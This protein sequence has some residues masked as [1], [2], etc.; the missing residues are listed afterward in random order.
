MT[1]RRWFSA[2]A[3]I[4]V[5][6]VLA[7][8]ANAGVLS[9]LP[10]AAS[11]PSAHAGVPKISVTVTSPVP[12]LPKPPPIV[13]H[14]LKVVSSVTSSLHV[15][16]PIS[17]TTT[18]TSTASSTATASKPPTTTTSPA[19]APAGHHSAG[20]S[21]GSPV[22]VRRHSATH[23][24]PTR[25]RVRS[26]AHGSV[27]GRVAARRAAGSSRAGSGGG[28]RRHR[29]SPQRAAVSSPAGLLS[30]LGGH[31]PLPLPVPNW[32]KPIILALLLIAIGFGI[33]AGVA[34]RRVRRLER[35]GRIL[36]ADFETMQAALVPPVPARV[37]GLDVSVGYQ[38][39][40]GP[41]AGG[42]FYEIFPL[43]GDRVAIILGDVSGH[44]PDALAHA[45]RM[46]FALRAYVE[47]GLSPR[48][49]LKLAGR[50][51][52]RGDGG[53]FTTV[54][55]AVY[56]PAAASLSYATAGHPPP[57]VVNP[58]LYEPVMCCASP[59]LG[60][61]F[62]TGARQTIV[63]FASG[64]RACFFTDGLAEAPTGDGL[65]G[66]EGIVELLAPDGFRAT[67]TEL[68]ERVRAVADRTRDDMATCLVEAGAGLPAGSPAV[69]GAG[70]GSPTGSSA[71]VEEFEVA[72]G[73]LSRA[74]LERFLQA[75]G[76]PP[77]EIARAIRKAEAICAEEQDALVTVERGTSSA[78][79]AVTAS[80]AMSGPG[81]EP[82]IA[83]VAA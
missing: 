22:T 47:T 31:I 65:L 51:A 35:Q 33:R 4:G 68:L 28:S 8:A 72:H 57:I 66:R 69:V 74:S 67:A 40:G 39:A 43:S 54:V 16:V 42:D 21:G 25:R 82:T 3:A 70:T 26:A 37:G 63:P 53:L 10:R 36:S 20:G 32:S 15:T 12:P 1:R 59:A 62:P 73:E 55:I 56:D 75:C 48:E 64:S 76:A 11:V 49:A 34:S 58:A 7:G 61:G 52:G 38:P 77:E 6:L 78:T 41:A 13:Q 9:A 24:R 29:R 14:V 18:V 50:V 2:L 44:G 80:A 83:A 17:T 60:W 5:T 45:A 23:P 79:V 71:V 30:S 46:H 81:S 19:P 27:R